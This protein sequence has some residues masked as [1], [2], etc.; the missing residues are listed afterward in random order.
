ML[1]NIERPSGL[2]ACIENSHGFEFAIRGVEPGLHQVQ[3]FVSDQSC[4]SLIM[5]EHVPDTMKSVQVYE[6]EYKQMKQHM[7]LNCWNSFNQV[8]FTKDFQVSLDLLNG[9]GGHGWVCLKEK[10][11]GKI[12]YAS[13]LVLHIVRE[14]E[15]V[16]LVRTYVN[17]VRVDLETA[18]DGRINSGK[19]ITKTIIMIMKIITILLFISGF[20][21]VFPKALLPGEHNLNFFIHD[22]SCNIAYKLPITKSVSSM[23]LPLVSIIIPANQGGERLKESCLSIFRQSYTNWEI[24]II[25]SDTEKDGNDRVSRTV[26]EIVP[27]APKVCDNPLINNKRILF[28][29]IYFIWLLERE[30]FIYGRV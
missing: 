1:A 4:T 19:I 14:S 26:K 9:V 24:I 29:L 25:D 30:I 17:K 6:S 27:L 21:F 13:P 23:D 5:L 2:A 18:C 11:R 22:S 20:R 12:G 28:S 3:Y 8:P 16:E 15:E 7:N 10:A